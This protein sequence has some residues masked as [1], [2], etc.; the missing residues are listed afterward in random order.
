[1]I[2]VW[3]ALTVCVVGETAFALWINHQGGQGL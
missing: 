2:R 3:I 1:M